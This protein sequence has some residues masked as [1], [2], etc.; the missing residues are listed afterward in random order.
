[1]FGDGSGNIPRLVADHRQMFAKHFSQQNIA[2]GTRKISMQALKIL[3]IG[4]CSPT[5]TT[6]TTSSDYS[7]K[8]RLYLPNIACCLSISIGNASA[9][10]KKPS[11][12]VGPSHKACKGRK[13]SI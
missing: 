12:P 9:M 6:S 5:S 3:G 8:V 7:P 10:L 1:M 4:K 13:G 2:N 11:Q